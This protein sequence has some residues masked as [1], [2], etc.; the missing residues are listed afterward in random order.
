MK[1][2]IIGTGAFGIAL[3]KVLHFNNNEVNMYTK[4]QEEVDILLLKRESKRLLPGVIIP[5]DIVIS[6]DLENLIQDS[7][8]VVIAVPMNAVR[9]VS[10]ELVKYL[11][12]EQIVCIVT[13]GIEVGTG[14]LMSEVVK[15]EIDNDNICMLSGPSFAIDLANN[16]KLGL[17][18]ASKKIDICFT[19]KE[20]FENDNITISETEDIA[21]IEIC[22]SAKNTFAIIMGMFDSE[23]ESTKAT[24]LTILLNDLRLI[25]E[26]LGGKSNS[27]FTYAGIGD[28]LLTCM[29]TKSRNY[30]FGT[31]I[32]KGMTKNEAFET[33]C[34]T[35]V[36]GIYS[37]ESI[38]NILKD[39]IIDIK[40][41]DILYNILYNGADTKEILKCLK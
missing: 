9:E 1:I 33:M 23:N 14:K 11:K 10:K 22:A 21:G 25:C 39:K 13:K 17:V 4:F 5:N 36:E 28:F 3:A 32:A 29:N 12:E 18:A 31:L 7:K 26:V 15:E 30:T 20:A 8:I 34:I 16:S 2:S 40:S 41:I 37:L 6:T 24:M 27:V 38:Y 35:T 19:I